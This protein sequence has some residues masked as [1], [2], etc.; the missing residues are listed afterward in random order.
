MLFG[1]GV[2]CVVFVQQSTGR[3]QA[4]RKGSIKLASC[5][6]GGPFFI[7]RVSCA[8]EED[9]SK[10]HLEFDPPASEEDSSKIH[11]RLR[12]RD[13]KFDLR[14]TLFLVQS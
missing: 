5:V 7:K 13:K 14:T 11:L 2:V 9:S 4:Q 12:L 3:Q 10:I 8:N 1:F 6:K